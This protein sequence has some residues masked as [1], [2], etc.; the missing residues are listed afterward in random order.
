MTPMALSVSSCGPANTAS[1]TASASAS[2]DDTADEA[3]VQG[4]DARVQ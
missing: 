1:E 2:H 4:D 3:T